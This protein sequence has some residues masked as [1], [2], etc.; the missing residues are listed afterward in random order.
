MKKV[1]C[2]VI[3]LLIFSCSPFDKDRVLNHE[4][5]LNSL[6]I[7]IIQYGK[8]TYDRDEV[9]EFLIDEVRKLDI[10]LIVLNTSER[11]PSFSGFIEETDSL[12]MFINRAGH[13]FNSEKRIIFDFKSIPRNFG[14]EKIIGASYE[15]FQLNNR[16][17]YSEIGFD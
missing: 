16:W 12:V 4:E 2:I 3:S 5:D 13:I 7:E 10:D 9:D 1:Y 11:N 15:V 14:D 8:G 17:Y 6:A